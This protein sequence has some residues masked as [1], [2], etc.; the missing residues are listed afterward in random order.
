MCLQEESQLTFSPKSTRIPLI[1][2]LPFISLLTLLA[3]NSYTPYPRPHGFHRI[4]LPAP[5][6]RKYRMFQNE[7]CP[8]SFFYPGEGKISRDLSDSC[9]VDIDFPQYDL[10]WHI[11]YRNVEETQKSRSTHFEEYRRMIYKHSKQATQ[12]VPS[13]FELEA[14]EGT[15]FE[16]YGNVGTPAQV[17]MYDS[18]EQHVMMMSFYFQTALKN[19]SL[20]PVINY[21]KEE[22]RNM[23][24]SFEWEE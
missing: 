24:D 14:G 18:T 6:A 9:W 16:I 15:F 10:K 17:F 4:E 3:C 19:D 21:M 12:I 8:F 20:L 1:S 13:T 2:F 22:V 7:T 5:E 11:T 23:M